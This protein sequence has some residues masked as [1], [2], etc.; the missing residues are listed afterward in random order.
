M[1]GNMRKLLILPLA[2]ALALLGAWQALA[3]PE[4]LFGDAVYVSPGHNSDRAVELSS[5][6]AG[7]SGVGFDVPDGTTFADLDTL[8]ADYNVTDDDCGGGSPRF[9][10]A[11]DS[12]GDGLTN[13]NVHIAIGPS[14]SFTGCAA[15]WQSTGNLIGNNDAG[16]Y[17][18]SGFGGSPFTDYAA[19]LATVGAH[20]VLSVRLI[21]DASW[22]FLD[23]EQ[24]V[25]VDNVNV[26][27]D[28]HTFESYTFKAKPW[29]FVGTV[30]NCGVA[31]VDSVESA[32][33]TGE[34]LPDAG[35]SDHAL[36]LQKL[37][38]TSNCAAAGATIEGVEGIVLLDIGWDVRDDGHCGAGAPRFNV[39]T[40]DGVLH[41]IGCNSPAPISSS[42]PAAGWHRF[43]YDPA[44]A[45]P[46]ITPGS[47]VTSINI[48]FD[49]GE[50]VGEG[51][52]YI[53]NIDIN[54][55]LIGKPG[56]A[57]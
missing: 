5:V 21:V 29:E 14:P 57:K 7:F 52:V 2:G 41:F 30:A 25:L 24:T 35:K 47:V 20:E 56:N 32:W 18:I 39:R 45:F 4:I 50:D 33:Q 27:G 15:G 3:E 38:P 40:D 55:V 16:R 34:G 10:L 36:Y 28:L 22:F 37:G 44:Q 42:V 53:D 51:F 11:L 17:D 12:D 48:V 46:P 49:E 13:G 9:S 26:D 43:R 8:S 31:G 54:G 6:G 19:A 23:G 1:E